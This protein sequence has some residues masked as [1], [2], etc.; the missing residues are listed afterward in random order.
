ML[1]VV[2][3]A[4]KRRQFHASLALSGGRRGPYYSQRPASARSRGPTARDREELQALIDIYEIDSS[5]ADGAD[6]GCALETE[7]QRSEIFDGRRVNRFVR[8]GRCPRS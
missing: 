5:A 7:A 6:T 8:A 3:P 2:L 1:Q 4:Y